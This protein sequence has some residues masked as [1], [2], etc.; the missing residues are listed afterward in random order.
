M[1]QGAYSSTV[2]PFLGLPIAPSRF[3][4]SKYGWDLLV[5]MGFPYD[6]SGKKQNKQTKKKKNLPANADLRGQWRRC[7]RLGFDPSVRKTL[8]SR[9][10]KPTPELM[11]RGDWQATVTG[12]AKTQPRLRERTVLPLTYSWEGHP[13]TL[14]PPTEIHTQSPS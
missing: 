4:T 8:W 5:R 10:W 9:K 2:L 3:P 13:G 1:G 11:D 7:K 6:A 14:F 12:V